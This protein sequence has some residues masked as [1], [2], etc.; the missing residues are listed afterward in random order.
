MASVSLLVRLKAIY[1]LSL[2]AGAIG[3]VY[4]LLGLIA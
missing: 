4:L 3:L 2:V 1:A